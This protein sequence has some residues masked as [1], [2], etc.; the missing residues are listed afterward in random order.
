[1]RSLYKNTIALLAVGILLAGC[2]TKEERKET[3]IKKEDTALTILIQRSGTNI[4]G[5]WEGG[6][7]E[8]LYQ[9]TGI[10]LEFYS[11]GNGENQRL[12]QYLAAGTLPDIIGFRDMEQAELL[13]GANVLINLEEYA[14]E[15][16]DIFKMQEYETALQYYKEQYGSEK[17]KLFFLPTSV[18]KQ[19]TGGYWMPMVQRNAYEKAGSPQIDTLEDYL[20]A[21]EL[22]LEK[23]AVT[24]LGDPVYGFS[25]CSD[26][27]E[28]KMQQPSSLY[29][30]YGMD[31]GS[32]SPLF[33]VEA[34]EKTLSCILGEKSFYERALHFF[35]EANQRGLLDPES[36]TQT[37]A[38]LKEKYRTGQILFSG[39][40]WQT[41]EYGSTGDRQVDK[42]EALP[43]K[44]MELYCDADNPVGANWYFGVN[45]NSDYKE[46][47]CEFLN[48]F[49]QPE[50][51]NLLYRENCETEQESEETPVFQ[52]LGLT[53]TEA[54]GEKTKGEQAQAAE[55]RTIQGTA[56]VY[57]MGALPVELQVVEKQ[58]Q[59]M[60]QELSW[61]M[62][63]AE[64]ELQF[65]ELWEEM[66]KKGKE[67]GIDQLN[68]YYQQ[69][70]KL[71]LEKEK[72]YGSD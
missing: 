14:S 54:D 17:E 66:Q 68:D 13:L 34:K 60:V 21:A 23:K 10:R 62:I 33:A 22:M 42:Y 25:L 9:D 63:Y 69:E 12:K 8:K 18:G 28:R 48:W 47:A 32:V 45:K 52:W 56:A 27:A 7:A 3:E 53:E 64:D 20:D 44:D 43:A 30:F 41:E 2:K 19:D 24:A 71:A 50:N 51:I 70:W 40:E 16:A 29:G 4:T 72:Q 58:I 5:T 59:D 61:E 46:Q 55:K 6:M 37:F 38:A 11:N 15:L 57:M 49:Y 39:Y 31:V 26:W 1:M 67:M 35:F 65:D 36:R